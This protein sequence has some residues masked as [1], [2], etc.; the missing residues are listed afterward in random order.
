MAKYKVGQYVYAQKH[1]LSHAP[2]T[3]GII[4]AIIGTEHPQYLVR[5]IE[6]ESDGISFFYDER[7]I[8][9]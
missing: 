5:S 9:K 3:I 4:T 6:G 2:E 8:S 7:L 1:F